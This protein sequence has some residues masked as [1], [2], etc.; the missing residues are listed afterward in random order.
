[1][2]F[3]TDHFPA[4]ICVS[5]EDTN[6]NVPVDI[7]GPF[8]IYEALRARAFDILLP[9]VLLLFVWLIQE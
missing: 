1:M 7:H 2:K 4:N 8:P 3:S 5:V 6:R 9:V